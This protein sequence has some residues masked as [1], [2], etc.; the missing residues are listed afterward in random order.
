MKS[1]RASNHKGSEASHSE[2]TFGEPPSDP[3]FAPPSLVSV[4][5]ERNQTAT[6]PPSHWNC[7]DCG[8]LRRGSHCCGWHRRVVVRSREEVRLTRG[9]EDDQAPFGIPFYG[10]QPAGVE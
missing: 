4:G 8:K 10:Y 1:A 7:P 3:S 9:N 5:V 2:V 6:K